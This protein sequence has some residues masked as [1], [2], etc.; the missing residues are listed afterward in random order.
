MLTVEPAAAGGTMSQPEAERAGGGSVAEPGPPGRAPH[1]NRGRRPSGRDSRRASSR[2]NR[3]S[4]VELELLGYPGQSAGSPPPP[5]GAAGLREPEETE[6]EEVETRAVAT[7]PDGRFL[8]FDIEIGRGSF[9]TVYKGLDTETTVEVAWC[10]LQTRKLSKTERQRFSEEVEMLKGLQHP[11]IVRF[12]DSWKSSVKGQ[13]CIVLVTELMTSGTLKTYLKRFKEMKLKVLQRWSRQILKGLHF[14]HTRSPPIIHRDLKCDNIFITGPTGSV[15]IGD[16]G[17]ATLKRA[18]FAKSVIGTPEF[19]APEMYEEKYDEAVD[20]YAFGMCMLEMATSEYPY[21]EC[22][23]AAQIYRK[24]TSGLKPSSFYKVKVPELKEIIEGCIRMDKDERYTIQDLLE[25]SFFQED[26]GVHV[27]LAEEDDGIK[28][29]LKLWLRMDDTKKLHGKYK[30]NNAIEFLFELYKDVAEEVAQ[31]M[32]VLGF[33]CEADYKLVAK[34]VRDR[35][36]AIKRKREKLKRAQDVVPQAELGQAPGVLQLLEDLKSPPGVPAPAPA[37]TGSRDSVFSS[38]FPPEPEEPEADQ[39][40]VYRHTSYSSATSDCETD[41]YLSSSGFLDSSDVSHRGASMGTPTS[42]PP[43][44]PARCFPTSI[45]VQLPTE[46]MPTASGFSSPVDSYASDVA[47]GMSDGC[48]GLSAGEQSTKLPARRAVG[49]LQRRRARSR[50]RITNISDKNDRV[51]ECQLQTYN[52]KMV[53]FKFDLDGDNPEEI[54]AVMVHN[55]FILKSEQDGFIHRIQDII[56][57]VETLLR[58]DGQGAAELPES[59]EAERVND[60]PQTELQLQELSHSIS[61]SSSLSDLGCTSPSLSLQSPVLP[62]PSSSPLEND[63]PSP[64]EPLLGSPAGSEQILISSAPSWMTASPVLLQTLPG[65]S[66]TSIPPALTVPSSPLPS[67]PSS[68]VSPNVTSTPW[69]PTTPLLSLANVFSLAVMSVAHTLLPAVS[70]IASSAVPLSPMGSPLTMPNT[71]TPRSPESST[72]PLVSLKPSH[73]LIVSESPAPSVPKARL[74]PINEEAK[75]QILGRFQVTPSK[76]PA[77]MSP[78]L[79]SSES[80]QHGTESMVSNSLLPTTSGTGSSTSSDSESELEMRVQDPEEA[81]AG[82]GTVVPAE[83]DREGP[84]EES[85]PQTVLSQVWLSSRSLSYVS[86]DDTESEDE[87]I[88]EELQTLRQKHLAEVQLLQSTQKKEIEEL[89]LRM[90]KQ[91]PL[92]IVSPAAM[93]SSRQRRLSKGSFNPSRRN[94]LQRLE[95]AQP[96]AGI[97]RRNSL[98]GSSTGSQE[99][100]LSKGVTFADDFSWM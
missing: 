15:K 83:S 26:T 12:Y 7:S 43:T 37:T 70:S 75:P 79:G 3:R 80:K 82:E 58:K 36:V 42:P 66:G 88:W 84:G 57:R 14:L 11:N 74:S 76:E 69:S 59:P 20:V 96:P 51:V 34:A 81:L 35:V 9:K 1:R 22:Q 100:R 95:L 53:T 41:G 52:N 40:F 99:Q 60:H 32:V 25:H 28:S 13:I 86:S 71:V 73:P 78:V 94:S 17:L 89:Y 33:V 64:A 90:G 27:E 63:L 55:E 24:V 54:A 97:M 47:S 62:A 18:S 50:L 21:S 8:K 67:E 31:E 4:S 68:P 5:P 39:H 48:E 56:H 72:V 6:S 44:R 98:S 16:L 61:S 2:F 10:E 93:L 91:P 49:R 92:G 30:D 45:A 38:T 65:T 85:A 29:G 19:M 87:E 46:H 77:V 23:N